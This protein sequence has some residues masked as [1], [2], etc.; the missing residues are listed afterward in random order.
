[1]VVKNAESGLAINWIL[2]LLRATWAS[3]GMV[4]IGVF[5]IKERPNGPYITNR[6]MRLYLR[7]IRINQLFSQVNLSVLF[8]VVPWTIGY[9]C[10]MFQQEC[11]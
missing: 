8:L 7:W 3:L 2:A 4:L 9:I 11:A 1:M 10:L 5:Q 6:R